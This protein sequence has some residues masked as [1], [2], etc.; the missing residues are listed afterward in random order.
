MKNKNSDSQVVKTYSY[1][2]TFVNGNIEEIKAPSKTAAR[3]ELGR[4]F[5]LGCA[6]QLA[7]LRKKY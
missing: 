2:A 6:P 4:L 3:K 7:S 5:S 1:I